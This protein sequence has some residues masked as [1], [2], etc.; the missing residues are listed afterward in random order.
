MKILLIAF[1]STTTL[2]FQSLKSNAQNIR[3]ISAKVIDSKQE[4]L[5]GN[6]L[7][8]SAEDPTFVKG[9]SFLNGSFELSDINQK[10]ITLKLT[11]LLFADTLIRIK[12][13]GAAHVDLGTIIVKQHHLQ[14][15]EVRISAQ[16]PLT[17]YMSNG[18]LEVKVANTILANSSSL[19]EILSRAPN[20]IVSDGQIAVA[21]KG[22][23]AIYLNGRLITA[24][25]MSSIPTSQIEK[26]EVISNPSSKYDA[27]GKAVINI[28]TKVNTGMGVLGSVGQQVTASEFAGANTNTMFDLNY[29]KGKFALVG[30]YGLFQG[31]NR[32]RLYTTRTRP[33]ENDYL[34]SELTTNWRRKLRNFSNYGLGAQYNISKDQSVSLG[35]SGNLEKQGGS[36]DSRNSITTREGTRFYT[37]DIKKDEGRLNHSFTLNY[38]QTTDTLGSVLFVGS[39]YS[40]YHADINDLIDERSLID[41]TDGFRALKND[42]EHKI[43][44]SSTQVDYTKVF[45][46]REKLEFGLKFSY[47]NTNSGTNFLIADNGGDFK[48][49]ENLSSDFEYR[50]KIPAAYLNYSG[51]MIGKTNF[52]IGLR[53]EWTNYTL[54]TSVGGGQVIRDHYFNVFPNLLLSRM[55]SDQLKLSA[56]YVSRITRP[57]YQALN[58]FVIYQDPF[59]TIEGNPNLQPEKVHS[60][61]LGANYR[62]V[63]LRVG[64]NYVIDPLTAAA[65]R[66]NTPNSYVLKGINLDKSHAYFAALSVSTGVGFWTAINTANLSYTKMIDDEFSFV[67][68]PS[69]PQWYLYSSNTFKVK[70]LFKLQLLA[71]YLG[72]RS[73][74]LYQDRSRSSV[75]IGIDKEFFNDALKLKFLANDI[76]SKTN[77]SGNY[78][79]GQTDIFYNRTYNNNYFRLM[80]TY[81]FGKLKNNSYKNKATGQAENNRAN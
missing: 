35:Y 76:F 57:R 38:N 42:V 78:S 19:T 46:S 23:A 69:R 37:S 77:S 34:R 24:E 3:S 32:E 60:F 75:S 80:A 41:G 11:S 40:D 62:K 51:L 28:I 7:L 26:I 36:Q 44:I 56:A 68:Q 31:S 58:P 66:G 9:I 22:E 72:D 17:R 1:L 61:E 79:V 43:L 30:N 27:E 29:N 52:G 47:V 49:D 73:S 10:E 18:N 25:R 59:T 71:W 54:N 65:L 5:M 4:P 74:G 67:S 70:N 20:V 2:F 15:N 48:P 16:Q 64:Y 81:S 50:E 12:Y 55:I 63:D 39:Q 8:H 6:A 45:R 21:G 14:L 13:K 53:G 33:S